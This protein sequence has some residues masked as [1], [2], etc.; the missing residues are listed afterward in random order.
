MQQLLALDAQKTPVPSLLPGALAEVR[1]PLQLEV[2]REG[3]QYHPNRQFAEFV[4]KG[5]EQGFRIG[6]SYKKQPKANTTNPLSA[7]QSPQ[8]ID[9]YLEK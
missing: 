3:L 8:V 7:S 6:L 2:W 1:T 9:D 4:A 5:I